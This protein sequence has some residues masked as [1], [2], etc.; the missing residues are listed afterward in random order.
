MR[1]FDTGVKHT[2]E[3]DASFI[4]PL[5]SALQRPIVAGPRQAR[6]VGRAPVTITFVINGQATEC[7]VRGSVSLATLLRDERGLHGTKVACGLGECGACTVLVDGKPVNACIFPAAKAQ[8]KTVE[9]IEGL[10]TPEQ[11][12]A[13]QEAFVREGGFQCG[14]CTPGQVM[15][16]HA[17]LR[18]VREGQVP[19]EP[20]A[21][22]H[23]IAG[24]ICRCTGYDKIVESIVTA[25]ST[26]E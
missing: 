17:L 15:R 12:S 21:I 4:Y 16:A 20:A 18:E 1:H 25:A 24:N 11:L 13:L 23:A 6:P 14:F 10:G 5:T 8:G 3:S 7:E 22:R 19:L 9:T 2:V 26:E